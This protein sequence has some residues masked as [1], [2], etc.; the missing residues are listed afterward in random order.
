MP[1]FTRDFE[2]RLL[3]SAPSPPPIAPRERQPVHTLYG[4]AHLFRAEAPAKLGAAALR[5]LDEH[6]PDA[7]SFAAA[8]GLS[9]AHVDRIFTRARERIAREPIEDMR[10]DFEDGYGARSDAEED[11]HASAAGRETAKALAAGALPFRFGIRVKAI[12][13]ATGP[14]ALRTLDRYF[15]ALAA[16]GSP[17]P[18]RFVV[19]LPKISSPREVDALA[20]A[21]DV[22]ERAIGAAPSSIRVEVMVETPEA[23]VELP[24]I[25]AAGGG[26]VI[27]AHLGAYDL[28]SSLGVAGPH[29]DLL[30]PL[31]DR[32]R[33]IMAIT[34][35][36]AG[37][38]LADGA[39]TVLPIPP[40][41]AREG[42][43]LGA[44]ERDENRAV[45]ARAWRRH[46]ERVAHAIRAGFYQGWDLHPAQIPARYAALYAFFSDHWDETAARLR[47]FVSAAARATRTGA[48]FDDAA[49]G[50][51]LLGF[52]LRAIASGAAT[53][54]EV[55][56]ATGL[57]TTQIRARS[58]AA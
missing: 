37:V 8:M 25:V 17:L 41:K 15:E 30:H 38:E 21:L 32:A 35:A 10:V 13:G 22:A 5:A 49:T 16:A 7:A 44:A 1:I 9:G 24:A 50:H 31:C 53:E 26:R 19:T 40:H 28:L 27:G 23:L 34:L 6:A 18:P 52:F 45:V 55:A 20:S 2:E 11:E 57:A 4:G 29:Y 36:R 43:A 39:T 12:A 51:G 3:A 42:A 48:L 47:T 58:W 33:E 56:S 54:D 46:A 14:R